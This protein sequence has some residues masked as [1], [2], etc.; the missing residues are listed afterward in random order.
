M[1]FV[2]CPLPG[3]RLADLPFVAEIDECW[4]GWV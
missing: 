4:R 3:T 2:E 1:E